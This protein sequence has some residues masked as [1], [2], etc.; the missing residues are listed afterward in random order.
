[1]SLLIE[2]LTEEVGLTK[3]AE[4]ADMEKLAEEIHVL[5]QSRALLAI[6]EDMAKIAC[7]LQDESL[8]M[9]A[10]D[11]GNTG[12]RLGSLLVKVASEDALDES[13]ALAADMY[14]LAS[15]YAEI[16]DNSEGEE[17]F[18]KM[19][20]TMIDISNEMSEDADE[21]YKQA[22]ENEKKE[23]FFHKMK[24]HAGVA[25][26]HGYGKGAWLPGS[27]EPGTVRH[28]WHELEGEGSKLKRLGQM[29][30]G[31]PG[32]KALSRP[33]IAYGT[34]AG[35]G[36]GAHKLYHHLHHLHHVHHQG[37]KK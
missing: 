15:A 30:S 1:M 4:E 34:A 16:A 26:H 21:F 13:L 29:L 7:E 23:G 35:A 25:A 27:K 14:K 17:V 20:E 6:A 9:L 19:A 37:H 5:D 32:L 22:A 31:K 11:T 33:L 8:A 18:V 36:Y 10:V 12:E 24:H 2:K 28:A 3:T